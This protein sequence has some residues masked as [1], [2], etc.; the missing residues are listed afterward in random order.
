MLCPLCV[1]YLHMHK[2]QKKKNTHTHTHTQEMCY[3]HPDPNHNT[4]ISSSFIERSK[5]PKVCRTNFALKSLKICRFGNLV[6]LEEGFRTLSSQEW[7]LQNLMTC[8]SRPKVLRLESLGQNPFLPI[9]EVQKY[10]STNGHKEIGMH[11]AF[12]QVSYWR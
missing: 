11:H 5:K 2:N 1:F 10:A 12:S 4:F 8:D 9:V 6:K 3:F 7:C